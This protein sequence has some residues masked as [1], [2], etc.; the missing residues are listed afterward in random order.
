MP[1]DDILKGHFEKTLVI[2]LGELQHWR[3]SQPKTSEGTKSCPHGDFQKCRAF[4]TGAGSI[5]GPQSAC[6]EKGEKKWEEQGGCG[7]VR[8]ERKSQRETRWGCGRFLG[9]V[10]HCELSAVIIL[11]CHL[12]RGSHTLALT[13]LSPMATT[14]LCSILCAHVCVCEWEKDTYWR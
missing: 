10:S 1:L 9:G 11:P 8:K 6:M 5:I 13:P 12:R 3:V 2:N 4:Q 7:D 14:G